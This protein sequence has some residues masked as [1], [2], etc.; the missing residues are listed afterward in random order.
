LGPYL[1]G[2]GGWG[3]VGGC[4]LPKLTLPQ[5]L[6]VPL[7]TK[8]RSPAAEI[9]SLTEGRRGRVPRNGAKGGGGG[10]ENTPSPTERSASCMSTREGVRP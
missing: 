6:Q 3:V 9:K 2:M 5:S 10:G 7:V 8:R 1:K 4:F